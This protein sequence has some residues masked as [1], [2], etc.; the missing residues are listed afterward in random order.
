MPKIRIE[1]NTGW[2]GQLVKIEIYIDDEKVGT[3]N[4]DETQDY[5]VENGK[6]KVHAKFGWERSKKIELNVVENE[7][8]VL[9]L[10]QYKYGT[11]I[12]LISFGLPPLINML[13]KDTLHLELKHYFVLLVLLLL[14]PTYYMIKNKY[15]VLTEIDKKTF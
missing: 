14:H 4:N 10:T 8:T 9:K 13:G 2:M 7:I 1:R 6:H 12:L 3:I 11:L 5:E 15:L